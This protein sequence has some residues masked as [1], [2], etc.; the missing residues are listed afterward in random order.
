MIKKNGHL[1]KL[2]AAGHSELDEND[3]SGAKSKLNQMT[4]NSIDRASSARSGLK[5]FNEEA[6]Q[7]CLR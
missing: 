1:I 6:F 7:E 2:E 3:S 4:G 5:D